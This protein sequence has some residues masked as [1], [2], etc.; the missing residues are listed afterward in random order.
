MYMSTF[1][2]GIGQIRGEQNSYDLTT[3]RT[4]LGQLACAA[5]AQFFNLARK[6]AVAQYPALY[7]RIGDFLCL[8]CAELLLEQLAIGLGTLTSGIARFWYSRAALIISSLCAS[9]LCA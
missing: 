5:A 6:A 9:A 2:A 3:F 1:D 4:S 8:F 7:R